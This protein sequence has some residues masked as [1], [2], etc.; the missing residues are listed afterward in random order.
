MRIKKPFPWLCSHLY[1]RIQSFKWF[2]PTLLAINWCTIF[3]VCKVRN[4]FEIDEAL[5]SKSC[6]LMN[7]MNNYLHHTLKLKFPTANLYIDIYISGEEI[8]VFANS[9]Q[10]KNPRRNFHSRSIEISLFLYSTHTL[11]T[12][13]DK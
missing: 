13:L 1:H 6:Y 8:Q 12:T 2:I 4:L 5:Q 11:P 3:R 9:N 10:Q 7:F